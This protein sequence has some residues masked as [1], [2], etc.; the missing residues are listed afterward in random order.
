M[1][2]G[3]MEVYKIRCIEILICLIYPHA[4][5]NVF[6][7]CPQKSTIK[8]RTDLYGSARI[9]VPI[10]TEKSE[11]KCFVRLIAKTMCRHMPPHSKR[12]SLTD[13]PS[14]GTYYYQHRHM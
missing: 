6:V 12:F 7:I 5:V 10:R 13:L 4:I 14:Q 2:G 9:S 3:K 11:R 8:F 1:S